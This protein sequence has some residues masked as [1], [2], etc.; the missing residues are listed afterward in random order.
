M[1]Y[2]F[3]NMDESIHLPTIE[4]KTTTVY[5]HIFQ[6]QFC[7]KILILWTDYSLEVSVEVV[8]GSKVEGAGAFTKHLSK[9]Q[10]ELLNSRERDLPDI[11][12]AELE[13]SSIRE[14][15]L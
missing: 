4:K 14:F 13:A 12:F 10:L 15:T 11:K 2:N 5:K 6:M 9:S 3:L 8:A 1:L 7:M